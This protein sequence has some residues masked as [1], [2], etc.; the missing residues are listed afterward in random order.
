MMRELCQAYFVRL[1]CQAYFVRFGQNMLEI[2]IVT[3]ACDGGIV[4]YQANTRFPEA[5]VH[6]RF[7]G[8]EIICGLKLD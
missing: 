4:A 5:L 3:V 1:L 7:H 8:R 6:K 2:T